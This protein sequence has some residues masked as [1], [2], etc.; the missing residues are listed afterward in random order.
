MDRC[1]LCLSDTIKIFRSFEVDGF[2][3]RGYWD[4]SHCGLVFLDRKNCLSPAQEKERYDQHRNNPDDKEYGRFLNRVVEPLSEKLSK[5]AHGLDYGCGPGPT[6]SVLMGRKGF[7]VSNY[8][9]FYFSDKKLLKNKYDF[10]TCTETIEHFYEPHKEFQLLDQMLKAGG[11][12]GVMTLLLTDD[13][14]FDHWWYR[15]DPTHVSFYRPKTV[16]WMADHL[17]WDICLQTAQTVI[18]CKKDF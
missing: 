2:G 9:P 8:D 10:I 5:G 12:L 17:D 18:F 3:P 11:Y 4:C 13:I 7:V 6:V 15:K 1:P 16:Q 14:D